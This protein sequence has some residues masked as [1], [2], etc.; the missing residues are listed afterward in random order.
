[1]R[2]CEIT[3]NLSTIEQVYKNK[4]QQLRNKALLLL[5]FAG[6]F[7]RSELVSVKVSDLDFVNGAM[8]V[9]IAKSKNDQLGKGAKKPIKASK[10]RQACPL[11]AV[12]AWIDFGGLGKDDFL[13]PSIHKSGK[14]QKKALNG[15]DVS[16]IVKKVLGNEYSSH[17]LRSGFITEAFERGYDVKVIQGT[18]LQ[19]TDSVTTSYRQI[20]DTLSCAIDAF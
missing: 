2:S 11:A 4:A 19:K 10:T 9:S 14:V 5:G 7:R 13:F 17:G 1:M 20:Q 12:Q 8:L 15:K 16:L 6:A 3:L 18:T